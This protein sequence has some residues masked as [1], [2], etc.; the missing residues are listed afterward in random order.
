MQAVNTVAYEHKF[1]PK[2]G[3]RRQ[4]MYGHQTRFEDN[5]LLLFDTEQPLRNGN[6]MQS[7]NSIFKKND[8]NATHK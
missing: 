6:H 8:Y 1:D 4:T 5:R 7:T 3:L 2:K